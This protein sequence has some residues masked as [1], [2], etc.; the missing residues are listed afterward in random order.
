[1]NDRISP[2][3]SAASSLLVRCYQPACTHMHKLNTVNILMV[4]KINETPWATML[5]ARNQASTPICL[6]GAARFIKVGPSYRDNQLCLAL[7]P[8]SVLIRGL[9]GP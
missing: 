8:D 6:D 9:W 3:V 2:Y 7:T 4:R 1:M 5:D